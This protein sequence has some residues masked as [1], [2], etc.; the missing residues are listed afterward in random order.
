VAGVFW[1]GPGG[2]FHVVDACAA[3]PGWRP[4]DLHTDSQIGKSGS[5]HGVFAVVSATSAA[6][7][8]FSTATC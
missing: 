5:R 7:G 6:A 4:D 2:I 3:R 8:S 1:Y